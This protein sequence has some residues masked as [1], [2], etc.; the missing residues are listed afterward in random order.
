MKKYAQ[1]KI[2]YFFLFFLNLGLKKNNHRVFF[3]TDSK[4]VLK[5]KKVYLSDLKK[6]LKLFQ[7]EIFIHFFFVKLTNFFNLFPRYLKEK[8]AEY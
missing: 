1:R 6:K 4:K 7:R 2:V 8:N 3:S 5:K